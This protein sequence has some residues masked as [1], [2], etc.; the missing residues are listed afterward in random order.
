MNGESVMCRK[1]HASLIALLIFL[2]L[3]QATASAQPES[4]SKAPT[5]ELKPTHIL[6]VHVSPASLSFSADGKTIASAAED[7]LKLWD[8]KS[9]KD[10]NR[11]AVEF[12]GFGGILVDFSPD[13]TVLAVAAPDGTVHLLNTGSGKELHRIA[14]PPDEPT[15]R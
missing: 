4:K 15:T 1:Q 9:G 7:G 3:L 10:L 6:D 8:V 5:I 2:C 14:P 13:G 12:R 11:F